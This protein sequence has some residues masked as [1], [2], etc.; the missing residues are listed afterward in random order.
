MKTGF[1]IEPNSKPCTVC[2]TGLKPQPAPADSTS[3][4]SF[5][6]NQLQRVF[7]FPSLLF[8]P[9]PFL[10]NYNKEKNPKKVDLISEDVELVKTLPRGF[11]YLYFFRHPNG[12]QFGQKLLWKYWKKACA[13]LGVEGVSVYPGTKHSTATF[14]KQE[15]G[16]QAAKEATG[17]T[18]DKAFGGYIIT[19]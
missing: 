10:I 12:K 1:G 11:P 3:P 6:P 7:L 17:H 14:L 8:S 5:F 2:L 4:K 9:L 19:T 16:Y 13:N 15:L 18:T